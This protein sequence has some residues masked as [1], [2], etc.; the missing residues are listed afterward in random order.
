[1][2]SFCSIELLSFQQLERVASVGPVEILTEMQ[3]AL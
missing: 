2:S 3:I 1:M